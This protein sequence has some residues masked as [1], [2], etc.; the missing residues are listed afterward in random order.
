[1]TNHFIEQGKGEL[2]EPDCEF[3]YPSGHK[4]HGFY[5]DSTLKENLDNNFIK[6][7]EAKWDGIFMVTGMEGSGKSN[8][9]ST[10][11]KYLDPNF[12]GEL[13]GDG[14]TH[15]HC[16]RI[17]FTPEEFLKAVDEAL[18]MEAIQCDEAILEFMA[19]DAATA[20][21]K[22]LSKKMVTIRKKRLYIAF[23]IPSIFDFR[24]QM[25]VRRTIFLIHTYS[26]DRIQRGS[27]KFYN[28]EAKRLLFM[29][30]KRDDNQN[31]HPPDFIGTFTDT[32]GLFFDIGEYD[33]K[34]NA[35]IESL[36]LTKGGKRAEDTKAMFKTKGQ[37]DLLLFY[38]YKVLEGGPEGQEFFDKMVK[39]REDMR[40]STK[41]KMSNA[42]FKQWLNDTFD[43]YVNLSE[44]TLAKYLEDAIKYINTK[45]KEKEVEVDFEEE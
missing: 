1:M 17:V 31:A 44:P 10:V 4:R 34:K 13:I 30:G 38:L 37:R 14:T 18:P 45:P 29:K 28:Y 43:K 40:N 15:R 3:T 41:D 20:V 5:I 19:G 32:E 25:A 7:V 24:K 36:S 12:P 9:T 16:T 33:R 6:S 22:L 21:Q 11:L 2:A 27:F 26:P 23:V 39:M 42:K 35:A 8:I